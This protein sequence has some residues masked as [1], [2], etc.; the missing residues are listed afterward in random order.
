MQSERIGE[1]GE[2]GSQT[3]KGEGKEDKRQWL[4]DASSNRGENVA[5]TNTARLQGSKVIGGIGGIRKDCGEQS[6]R[7]FRTTWGG[8]PTQSAICSGNDG[9][10]SELDGITFSNW[11]VESLKGAGNAIVPQVAFEIFKAIEAI[12]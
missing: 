7:F 12:R 9:I 10:S 4:W 8:F 11:R 3:S 2:M 6:S 5:D 1:F